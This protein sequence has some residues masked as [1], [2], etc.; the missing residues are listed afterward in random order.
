MQVLQVTLFD[1]WAFTWILLPLMIFFAR[2]FDQ[3]IG[4]LR[5]VFI[6]KG[7]KRWAPILGFMESL[8]WLLAIG[9]I[10]QHLDNWLCYAAYA[11]GFA[12][13][14][15]VGMKLDERLSLGNVIIRIILKK[16]AQELIAYLKQQNYGLTILDAEGATGKVKVIF[17]I[18][19]RRDA[20]EVISAINDFDP[21]SFYTIEEVRS[22]NEGVFRTSSR[23]HIFSLN[24]MIRKHK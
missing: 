1:S 15:Y 13:G 22:V 8:T 24:Q 2:I 5:M 18:V 3:S 17:S 19:K 4:T 11:G 12:M 16:Q 9:Q 10:M 20:R 14:N 7:M 23:K 6:A 21:H